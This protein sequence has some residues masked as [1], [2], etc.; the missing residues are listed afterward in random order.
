MIFKIKEVSMEEIALM[1]EIKEYIKMD[2]LE[3]EKRILTNKILDERQRYFMRF[4][5]DPDY[6]VIPIHYK[7]LLEVDNDFSIGCSYDTYYG[8]QVI[9]S[10]N[11]GSVEDVKV[12]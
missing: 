8:M 7:C 1:D 2:I 6:V 10:K 12:Y 9:E 4:S 3:I 11:C 5:E